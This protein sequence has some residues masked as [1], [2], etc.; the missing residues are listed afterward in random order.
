MPPSS[1]RCA[2]AA[3]A[4]CAADDR[5][6]PP[7]CRARPLESYFG[8][9]GGGLWKT[10][11]DGVTWNPVTDGQI[12]APRSAQSPSP[13][14]TPISSSS[15]RANPAARQHHAGRRRLQVHRRGPTWRQAASPTRND[16][17]PGCASTRRTPRSCSRG[18][19]QSDGAERRARRVSHGRR[20]QARW[21][22]V[23]FR[24]D[25]DRRRR[26]VIDPGI[27]T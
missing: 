25:E 6:P 3:S 15:A 1:R 8:A 18:A 19:R 12:A 4:R 2:G 9:T 26:S 24:D 22:K 27:P 5:L 10:T 21:R 16:Q 7:A 13:P 17:S 20:R 14:R 11:D 23:L